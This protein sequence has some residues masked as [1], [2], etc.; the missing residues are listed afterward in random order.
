MQWRIKIHRQIENWG[1]YD[2]ANTFRVFFHLL[3][4]A[5]HWEQNFKG[6]TLYPWQCCIGRKYLSHKLKLTEQQ[7]RRALYNLSKQP[8]N[9]QQ[10]T[11]NWTPEITIKTTNKYSIITICKWEEY[12]STEKKQPTKQPTKQPATD[13][14]L[15]WKTTTTKE[16]K[17]KEYNIDSTPPQSIKHILS[18]WV[19]VEERGVDILEEFVNYW[20][21]PNK[22][23]KEKRQLE[24]T[25]DT[26]LRLKKWKKN[27]DTNFGTKQ[28]IDYEIVDNY[29]I[30]Y[31]WW[32]LED[33]KQYFKNKYPTDRQTKYRQA[34]EKYRN[35]DLFIK[36]VK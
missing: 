20:S 12:Q 36:A 32:K 34:K 19:L 1:W 27:K 7:I 18:D 15:I 21:E 30:A 31:L 29:H 23:G 22:A 6:Q 26:N 14:E 16:Y 8:T 25:W 11:S 17:N 2:D 5:S 28:I 33:V 35:S 3:I 10:T 9:N 24:R 4:L 13:L